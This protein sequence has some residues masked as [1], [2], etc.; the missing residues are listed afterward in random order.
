MNKYVLGVW[1]TL[2]VGGCNSPDGTLPP[3]TATETK[4]AKVTSVAVQVIEPQELQEQLTLPGSLEAWEDLVLSAEIDGPVRWIGPQEG[5]RLKQG[6][7]ILKID[8]DTRQA[9]L[10]RARAECDLRRN[11]RDRFKTLLDEKLVSP[12]EYEDASCAYEVAAAEL[13]QAQVAIEQSSLNSPVAGVLDRLLVDRGEHVSAGTPVASVVQVDRLKVVLDV[14]EKDVAYLHAGERVQVVQATIN[15]P[16]EAG[17]AGEL[18]HLAYKADPVTRTY[19]AKIAVD[20][21]EGRLRPGMIVRVE[22]VR[23]DLPGAIAVPLYALVE[24]GGRKVAYV[25]ENG[26]ARLREVT[27]GAV[28]G[29][30]VLIEAGL[31]AGERLLVKGQHLVTDGGA[32]A[33]AGD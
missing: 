22:A 6:E 10:D 9:S 4:A 2:L 26:V 8:P 20:N 21:A 3:A 17:V 32:I 15:G 23:R 14:P 5:D 28:I 25:A 24:Q 1:L 19:Q 18:I 30:Q 16:Q 12:Q 31:A 29:D 27:T 13:R 7:V 11:T 33:V